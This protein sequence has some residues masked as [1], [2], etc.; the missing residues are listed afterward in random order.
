MSSRNAAKATEGT[1]EFRGHQTWYQIVGDRSTPSGK[2]PL[3]VLHGGP[4]VPHDYLQDLAGLADGDRAVVFYDQLGCG[5]SDHPDDP[6]AV[7]YEHLRRR[8]GQ[9]A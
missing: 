6:D 1:V 7:G 8:V 2:L 5:R 4:G 3:L 9:P